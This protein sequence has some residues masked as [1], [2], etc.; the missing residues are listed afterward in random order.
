M[1]ILSLRSLLRLLFVPLLVAVL[2]G[3]ERDEIKKTTVERPD[4]DIG[5]GSVH[6]LAAIAESG[7][8]VW[9]FKLVGRH[10]IVEVVSP[11]FFQ[12][13]D[14]LKFAPKA[15]QTLTWT[16]PKEWT[17]DK[18]KQMRFATLKPGVEG[19]EIAISKLPPSSAA[20]KPNVDRWR[21]L[22]LNLGKIS[23]RNLPKVHRQHK[24]GDREVTIV[25]MRGP[26]HEKPKAKPKMDIFPGLEQGKDAG[27]MKGKTG[28]RGV[29]YTLPEG[30]QELPAGPVASA[31]IG[32]RDGGKEAQVA[33]T[34]IGGGMLGGL[35]A[36]VNRWRQEVSLAPLTEA[37]LK[38]LGDK[39]LSIDQKPA[40][41][42]DLSGSSQRS[43]VVWLEH[44]DS[45]WYFKLRGDREVVAKN[46]KKYETFLQS[47]IFTGAADE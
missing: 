15:E 3:C 7:E 33:I 20:L 5:S 10:D 26:G 22:D 11:A 23:L 14:S 35:L 6:L 9:F 37:D 12:V 39:S 2:A 19:I 28:G 42:L 25:D 29:K 30:W 17:E 4:D 34:S 27:P 47:V 31:K 8:D 32:I 13:I 44:N 1:K 21:Q 24:V 16:V 46:L 18:S 43:V 38:S 36:N 45:M 40:K 41:M